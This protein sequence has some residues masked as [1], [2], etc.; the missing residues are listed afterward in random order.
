MYFTDTA[1]SATEIMTVLLEEN[2]EGSSASIRSSNNATPEPAL[3]GTSAI[4]SSSN[5]DTL[6]ST[7]A[8][9]REIRSKDN[10]KGASMEFLSSQGA[11]GDTSTNKELASVLDGK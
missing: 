2:L 1:I 4:Q 8:T 5:K 10:Q 3:A 11:S 7:N 6:Q 9:K